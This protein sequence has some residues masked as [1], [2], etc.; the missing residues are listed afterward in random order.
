MAYSAKYFLQRVKAVNE[1]YKHWSE[2]GLSNETVYLK[3]IRDSFH[4]S[5][6]TFYSYL[7]IPYTRLL[8]DIETKE[9]RRRISEPALF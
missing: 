2:I 1:V 4:I 9:Q 8:K 5:R 3:H 6:S 7:A